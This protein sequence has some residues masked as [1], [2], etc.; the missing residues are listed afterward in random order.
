VD[1]VRAAELL[2]LAGRPLPD[3]VPRVLSVLDPE[4]G[5]DA[6]LVADVVAAAKEL[7]AP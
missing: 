4:L 2:P 6:A 3:A 5:A 7:S 1:D